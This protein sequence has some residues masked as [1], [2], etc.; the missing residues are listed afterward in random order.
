MTYKFTKLV[1]IK[2]YGSL[3]PTFVPIYSDYVSN[4]GFL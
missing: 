4:R 3:S 1:K 2:M